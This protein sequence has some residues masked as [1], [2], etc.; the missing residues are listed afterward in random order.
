MA[1]S[2]VQQLGTRF[3]CL[4]D[5]RC[6]L[7]DRVRCLPDRV[8]HECMGADAKLLGSISCSQLE[9]VGKFK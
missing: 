1:A 2:F 9:F 4:R 3:P 5:K 6:A 8:H 7:F